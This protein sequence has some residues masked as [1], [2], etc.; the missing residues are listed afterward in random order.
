M[1]TQNLT[2]SK[3]KVSWFIFNQLS[4]RA[5]LCSAPHFIIFFSGSVPLLLAFLPFSLPFLKK[6]MLFFYKDFGLSLPFLRLTLSFVLTAFHFR[7]VAEPPAARLQSCLSFHASGN[8]C[9]TAFIK[10]CRSQRRVFP[11]KFSSMNLAI[12]GHYGPRFQ[13]TEEHCII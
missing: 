10:A 3:V 6:K 8:G 1:P 5:A 13:D 7:A 2:D 11:L 9:F 4:E 12:R